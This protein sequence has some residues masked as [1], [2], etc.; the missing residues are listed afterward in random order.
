MIKLENVSTIYLMEYLE[1]RELNSQI[2]R[3]IYELFDKYDISNYQKLKDLLENK[4]INLEDMFIREYLKCELDKVFC[5][6]RDA[7]LLGKEPNIYTFDNYMN[8]D[9][10]RRTLEIT[11]SQNN[12]DI[13]LYKSPINLLSWRKRYLGNYSINLIKHYLEHITAYGLDNVF[14][15]H[16][17]SFG[18]SSTK[19]VVKSIKFYEE[20]VLRQALETSEREINLFRLNKCEKDE[21][22]EEE[23][24]DIIEY[25]VDNANEC[26]WGE[27]TDSQKRRMLEATITL[28]KEEQLKVRRC[29]VDMIS[30]YTTLG[31]LEEGIV[32]KRVLDRFIVR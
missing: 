27:L 30:N 26:I 29:L 4:D 21:I 19:Q 12:G 22:V 3:Y 1:R 16:V 8:T 31:E 7:N 23:F 6:V 13:L 25:I 15:T 5:R 18:S 2:Y 9:I 32:K 28:R 11:D 14:I 24:R 17:H 20:Q 10:D